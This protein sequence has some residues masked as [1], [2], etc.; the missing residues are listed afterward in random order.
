MNGQAHMYTEGAS[1]SPVDVNLSRDFIFHWADVAKLET[2]TF[3]IRHH[4][5]RSRAHYIFALR[6]D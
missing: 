6:E 5:S 3:R 1:A 4:T 2:M